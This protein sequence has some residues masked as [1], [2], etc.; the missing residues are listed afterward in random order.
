MHK[1]H[2]CESFLAQTELIFN[3]AN[4]VGLV[5]SKTKKFNPVYFLM[6]CFHGLFSNKFSLRQLAKTYGDK[7]SYKYSKTSIFNCFNQTLVAFL[8][9]VLTEALKQKKGSYDQTIKPKND[10]PY[11]RVLVE[12]S[13][14][15]SFHVNLHE[16]FPAHGNQH[17]ETAGKKINLTIDLFTHQTLRYDFALATDQDRELGKATLDI[18][19]PNDLL[20]RDMGYFDVPSFQIVESKKAYWLTRV[21]ANTHI[22]VPAQAHEQG[23][24]MEPDRRLESYLQS[25]PSEQIEVDIKIELTKEHRHSCR[26][27]AKRAKQALADKRKRDL[28]Q[29][30]KK[31]G[32]Q[33]T[34]E[35]LT[36]CEWH[37]LATNLPKEKV[38]IDEI[39][40]LYRHRWRIE[41]LFKSFKQSSNWREAVKHNSSADYVEAMTLIGLLQAILT[42]RCYRLAMLS[43]DKLRLSM[44]KLASMV[45]EKLAGLRSDSAEIEINSND[46][47]HS[48]LE[49]RKKRKPTLDEMFKNETNFA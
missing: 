20:M 14:Q 38:G 34:K 5:H 8:K 7:S 30:Y 49:K 25:L 15:L 13:T 40:R 47:Y 24:E 46:L 39:I 3:L 16:A 43:C 36:L 23:K 35:Q 29:R 45:I 18:I 4:E 44:Q 41:T 32:K 9:L 11:Q 6:T 21:P 33:P 31:K 42:M 22:Y 12:D 48:Q 26:L 17:G 27:V 19:Q 37:I 28:I 2:A 10:T 1:T